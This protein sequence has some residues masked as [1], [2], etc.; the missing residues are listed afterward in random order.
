MFFDQQRHESAHYELEYLAANSGRNII[1]SATVTLKVGGEPV[2]ESSTG[3]GPVDAA[4]K[5]IIKLLGHDKIEIV[6]FKLDSKG[7]GADALAQVSVV[8]EYGGRRFHGIGL[9]TDIVESGVKSLIHVLN[10]TYLADQIDEQ[11][12]QVIIKG[13]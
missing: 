5:A 1:P 10:N 6:D 2:T 11:K 3:N 9:A 8:A 12:Q 4:F 7:E 13:V